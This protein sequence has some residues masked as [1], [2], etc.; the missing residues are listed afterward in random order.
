MLKGLTLQKIKKKVGMK[1]RRGGGVGGGGGGLARC[2][3]KVDK[4]CLTAV[5]LWSGHHRED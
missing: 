1:K 4:F 3:E 2:L 5:F